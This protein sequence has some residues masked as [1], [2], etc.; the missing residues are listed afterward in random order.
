[1]AVLLGLECLTP[2][3]LSEVV[4]GTGRARAVWRAMREGRDPYGA[5]QMSRPVRLRL[6]ERTCST[7]LALERCEIASCRTRK[8]RFRLADG[9]RIE[10]VL[11]ISERRTTVCVST[12]VGC[13]RGCIFCLTATMGLKRSLTA[14]EIVGQV[15]RA[16]ADA[17]RAALPPV[18][19]VVFMGMGEPLDNLEPLRRAISI[20]CD[21]RALGL[22]PGHITLS[23]V[24]TTPEAILSTRDLKV[25]LA[26]S[27]HAV[28]DGLRR[29]LIP[30]MRHS[31]TDLREAFLERL[32]SGSSSLFVEMTL[33]E[34]LNDAP[35]H[36]DEL[37]EF[38]L[39]FPPGVRINLLAM[40]PGRSAVTPSPAARLIGFRRRL[41]EHGFFCSIRQPKGLDANAACGQLL[42][43]VPD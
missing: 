23:T 31:T 34:G 26:W 25:Q 29:R 18:R 42:T 11:I 14:G 9:K 37:A 16:I 10:T 33:M 28:D 24:G 7:Y 41:C 17:S 1:M 21:H 35:H 43:D 30:T 8:F 19:N 13:G 15:V 32:K 22:G 39:P 20:L 40:N 27:L 2:D 6:E 5:E 38:L 36:A 4:G 12:Q 3:E